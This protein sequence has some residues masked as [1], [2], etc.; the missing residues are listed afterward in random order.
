MQEIIVLS[1]AAAA[2]IYLGYQ[3]IIKKSGHDCDKC[4]ANKKNH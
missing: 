3:L 4:D 2:L 1:I